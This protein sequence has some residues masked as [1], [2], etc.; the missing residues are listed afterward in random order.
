MFSLW[1]NMVSEIFHEHHLKM[2]W[3]VKFS[4]TGLTS[5]DGL[6]RRT[7]TLE[8]KSVRVVTARLDWIGWGGI[9]KKSQLHQVI[10]PHLHHSLATLLLFLF[11]HPDPLQKPS[12]D[13][14]AA[15]E[16]AGGAGGLRHEQRGGRGGEVVV[17]ARLLRVVAAQTVGGGH[18]GGVQ[19]GE[20]KAHVARATAPL[21]VHHQLRLNLRRRGHWV[22][23]HLK[24]F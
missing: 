8:L 21:D 1:N 16:R 3:S 5:C 2:V 11:L 7:L 10:A 19:A 22:A 17:G 12:L 4:Q 18:Q 23:A 14:V 9:L 24:Q 15:G 20:G 6:Y 13:S